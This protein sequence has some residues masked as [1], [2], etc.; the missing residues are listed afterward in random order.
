ML[1]NSH[2]QVP[3]HVNKKVKKAK[4]AIHWRTQ[5]QENDVKSHPYSPEILLMS[6]VLNITLYIRIFKSLSQNP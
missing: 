3:L 1:E 6:K 5:K 4:M 2:P